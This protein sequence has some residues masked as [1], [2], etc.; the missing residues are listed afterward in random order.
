[1][2]CLL[3]T[4]LYLR[5]RFHRRFNYPL[6]SA[7]V[8]AGCLTAYIVIAFGAQMAHLKAAKQ[9]SYDSVI[10]LLEAKSNAYVANAAESRYLLDWDMA[11]VHEA[12]FFDEAS[13]L[14]IFNKGMTY[15][16]AVEMTSRS[17][18]VPTDAFSGRLADELNNITFQ[19]EEYIKRYGYGERDVATATLKA[20]GVYMADDQKI[21]QL[22]SSGRHDEAVAF[23]LSY[24]PG[25]S[26]WAF[27]QFD[28]ALDKTLNINIGEM[29]RDTELGF[30]DLRLLPYIAP[31]VAFLIAC[32]TFVGL[33]PRMR[34]FDV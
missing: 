32:L 25:D 7:T 31:L 30:A 12:T 20:W 10:A 29:D 9:D 19:G 16:R 21:R 3:G 28:A 2:I 23:C 1:M 33:R 5:R 4:Q 11:K 17:E 14:V 13:K 24:K 18:L 26:N 34:E 8:L 15:D 27:A 22:E 6:L